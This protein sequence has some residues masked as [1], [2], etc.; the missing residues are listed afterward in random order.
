[1]YI[2]ERFEAEHKS[3]IVI[4]N[5][6][7]LSICL[8]TVSVILILDALQHAAPQR[9]FPPLWRL[10]RNLHF[11]VDRV[12][13]F[14]SSA[15]FQQFGIPPRRVSELIVEA[16]PVKLS[17]LFE[18]LLSGLVIGKVEVE[19]NRYDAVHVLLMLLAVLLQI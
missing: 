4:P 18:L 1:M 5:L 6:F 8:G 11:F 3:L 15:A 14:P 19:G 12:E 10:K 13:L 2:E 9:I 17:E 16:L 7:L